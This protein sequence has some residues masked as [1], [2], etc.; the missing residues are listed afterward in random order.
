MWK[1]SLAAIRAVTVVG[2]ILPF[3]ASFDV[4]GMDKYGI[5]IA[6]N[7]YCSRDIHLQFVGLSYHLALFINARRRVSLVKINARFFP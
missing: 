6:Q 3:C 2:E 1:I 4:R 5:C 7:A